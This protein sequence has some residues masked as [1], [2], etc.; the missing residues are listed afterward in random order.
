MGDAPR[1]ADRARDRAILILLPILGLG[2]S[3]LVGLN[4]KATLQVRL[5]E[6]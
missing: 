6:P 5:L 2:I 1:E 4:C 3:E